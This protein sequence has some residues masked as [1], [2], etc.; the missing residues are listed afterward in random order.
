[1]RNE[2]PATNPA[3]QLNAVEGIPAQQLNSM[4]DITVQQLNSK[5]DPL[6]IN[7]ITL[8]YDEAVQ[9]ETKIVEWMNGIRKILG[10]IEELPNLKDIKLP[11]HNSLYSSLEGG[12]IIADAQQLPQLFPFYFE[13]KMTNFMM[14]IPHF[15]FFQK[16]FLY[17]FNFEQVFSFLPA[18][19]TRY[20]YTSLI[21]KLDVVYLEDDELLTKWLKYF[22]GNK[23][24]ITLPTAVGIQM[25]SIECKRDLFD[26]FKAFL[27]LYNQ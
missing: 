19:L 4:E 26:Y 21:S 14:E 2:K 7:Q 24:N 11:F 5:E 6:Y 16:A 15:E 22:S 17:F 27:I 20:Q 3:Q 12:D 18:N 8:S 1:M 23:R 10:L 25:L 13:S 9:Q